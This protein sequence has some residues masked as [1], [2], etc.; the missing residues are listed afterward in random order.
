MYAIYIITN[1]VNA[2]QYV[3]ITKN[4]SKR[5]AAHRSATTSSYLHKSIKKYGVEKFVFTH[6]AD[7]FSKD[8]ACDIER[9]LIVEHNT[10]SPV[11]YNMT[12]GGDGIVKLVPE[13]RARIGEA[14]KNRSI[15]SRQSMSKKLTGTKLSEETKAKQRAKKIGS[16]RSEETKAKMSQSLIGN[17]RMLGKKHSAETIAK[18]KA[19]NLATKAIRKAQME[20]D[21]KKENS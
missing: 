21:L 4:L 9:M 15:E 19:S 1:T 5:W 10:K 7:A 20:A 14:N 8:A 6:Y 2:K 13:S 12:D 11:G 18:I 3:G 17:T 16:K